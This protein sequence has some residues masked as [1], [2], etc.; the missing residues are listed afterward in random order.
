MRGDSRVVKERERLF[1]EYRRRA[2]LS[3][4]YA[5]WRTEEIFGR[6]QARRVAA[7]LLV[8]AGAFPEPGQPCLEVGYGTLGWLAELL[9]W[10]LYETDL[11]GIEL[12]AERARVAQ[13]KLP[14]A[15]L[16]VGDA[17]G[18]PWA[19]ASFRLVVVS[20]VF[21]SVLDPAVRDLLA[22]EI[23]RVLEPGGAL[24]FYDLAV[25]NPVNDQVRGV[26][27]R[28]IR[29]LFPTLRGETRAVTLAPP[30]ARRIAP[31][32]WTLATWLEALPLLRTHLLAVLKKH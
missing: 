12:D 17:T 27:R 23:E 30:L 22:R 2:A 13:R 20:T 32:S 14:A 18:L 16:R 28:E 31:W 26:R 5:P 4:R 8:R 24:L 19:D 9:T 15:D 7:R 25:N 1:V 10:G 29:E 21:S 6:T 3:D 11:H